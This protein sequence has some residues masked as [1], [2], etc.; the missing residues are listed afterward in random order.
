MDAADERHGNFCVAYGGDAV[1]FMRADDDGQRLAG[2]GAVC[3]QYRP[4]L[5]EVAVDCIADADI[6]QSVVAVCLGPVNGEG[7]NIAMGYFLFPLAMML[8]G[9]I[10]FK[11]RL[12]RLQRVAVALA[13]AGVACEL[14]RSGA[15][16]WTTVWVFGTYPFYYLPR[17]KLG[18]P[19]LIGLTFDLMMITP[20]ALAYILL[21][22]DTPAMIAA[23][24]ALIFF[25]VLL[26]F[27][28]AISMHLNLKANQ[29][30]PVAVFGMLSYLEPVL[31]F[32]V[33]IVWLGEP[34]QKGALIGYGLIWSG[35]CVMIVNGLLGM[36]KEKKLA[37]A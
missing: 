9:R 3:E 6:C 17:R 18:V 7:V 19:S 2:C 23:K 37:K 5:E 36:K 10:W 22:T 26:G 14:V 33:S 11:E 30:L 13:C 12:N 35:L 8:G 20:F 32:I 15:F 25:I 21:A 31:L 28:S 1:G 16:S 29:L 24:P 4:R 27:N 34:V